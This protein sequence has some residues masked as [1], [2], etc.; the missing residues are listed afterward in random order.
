MSTIF[1]LGC[2]PSTHCNWPLWCMTARCR[3]RFRCARPWPV[4][5]A[6]SNTA[7]RHV[8]PCRR[9]AGPDRV[10]GAGT[11]GPMYCG[12]G[13]TLFAAGICAGRHCNRHAPYSRALDLPEGTR[14]NDDHHLS[15]AEKQAARIY[16]LDPDGPVQDITHL[17]PGSDRAQDTCCLFRTLCFFGMSPGA[18]V[19]MYL[20]LASNP[21]PRST[22]RGHELNRKFITSPSLTTYSLPSERIL[23]ASLAP[24]SPWY[25]MKSSKA[26]VWAR[27]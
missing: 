19:W 1:Q 2:G 8:A 25:A 11:G 17:D 20:P 6:G 10:S 3:R 26:M 13:R 9:D 23:P 18:A 7:G 4:P 15:L 12:G 5:A 14:I 22:P 21:W 27:M 24:C 16:Y